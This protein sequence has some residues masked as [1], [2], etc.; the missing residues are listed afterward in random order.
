MST[1]QH[2]TTLET[3][4]ELDVDVSRILLLCR[5]KRLGYTLPR[6]GRAWVI[7]AQE[8]AA[9]R[10]IGPIKPGPPRKPKRRPKPKPKRLARVAKDGNHEY[11]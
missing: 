11:V 2:Y 7:T 1:Q 8:I 9:Y 10:E 5:R 4:V 3:A 6:H